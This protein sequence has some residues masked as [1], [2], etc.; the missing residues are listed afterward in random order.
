MA[1]TRARRMSKKSV[2]GL[3]SVIQS[4]RAEC[5]AQHARI[6]RLGGAPAEDGE[7]PASPRRKRSCRE[8]ALVR[9]ELVP[10]RHADG[11]LRGA[12]LS[13]KAS[14]QLE[15]AGGFVGEVA[16][17]RNGEDGQGSQDAQRS[18]CVERGGDAE[19]DPDGSGCR[20]ANRADH[21]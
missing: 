2:E 19:R 12:R 4:E 16:N 9:L 10:S 1:P 21:V 5:L 3:R 8:P 15:S 11:A 17:P 6:G 14:V 7:T 18:G 13:N 20:Q